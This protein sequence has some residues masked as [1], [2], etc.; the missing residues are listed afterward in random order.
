M[1]FIQHQYL[2]L[3]LCLSFVSLTF[4]NCSVTIPATDTTKPNIELRIN[5]PG[6]NS[7]MKNPPTESWAAESGAQLFNLTPGVEYNFSL[8]VSDSGGV[9]RAA[10]YFPDITNFS[11]IA[12]STVTERNVGI[13]TVLTNTGSRSNPLSGLTI[14]GKFVIPNANTSF[15]INVEADDFGGVSGSINQR[16]MSVNVSS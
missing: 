3:F 15:N 9:K 16:F 1:K 11:S 6:V 8:I 4:T 5:G 10:I 12:P 2:L 13:S 14:T 7:T